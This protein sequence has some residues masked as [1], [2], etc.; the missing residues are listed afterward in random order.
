MSRK[1]CI[2]TALMVLVLVLVGCTKEEKLNYSYDYNKKILIS[3][4]KVW[5]PKGIYYIGSKYSVLHYI[6]PNGKNTILCS[7]PE[8]KHNNFDCEAY[9][10]TNELF[11]YQDKLCY[12]DIDP[13]NHKTDIYTMNWKGKERKKFFTVEFPDDFKKQRKKVMGIAFHFW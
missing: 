12:M 4:D 3:N 13:D 10:S 1:I 7:K 11:F 9:I 2:A 6:S 8:C 5:T